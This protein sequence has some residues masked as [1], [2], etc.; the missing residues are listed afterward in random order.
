VIGRIPSD[1]ILAPSQRSL[2]TAAIAW[3]SGNTRSARGSR[4]L[5]QN[6]DGFVWAPGLRPKYLTNTL[7]RRTARK[8][9][10]NLGDE[11]HFLLGYHFHKRVRAELIFGDFHGGDVRCQDT[12]KAWIQ[13]IASFP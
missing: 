12:L 8:A 6:S 4:A 2:G 7:A 13:I 9:A 5:D 11:R 3:R 1:G 10:A